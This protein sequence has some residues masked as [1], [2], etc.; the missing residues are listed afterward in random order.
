MQT[1]PA[2]NPIR[3]TALTLDYFGS[4]CKK[5][6]DVSFL[7]GVNETNNYYGGTDVGS[8]SNIFFAN[9]VQDP[10]QWAGVRSSQGSTLPAEVVDCDGCAH[11]VDLY[12]PTNSDP[13]P[14]KQ[15]RQK[16]LDAYE[17]WLS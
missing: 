1:A 15:E 5:L 13:K 7:P 3:S 4:I 10:W 17:Q 11:C 14:L 12:T 9:G 2:E 6:F 8:S 16:V